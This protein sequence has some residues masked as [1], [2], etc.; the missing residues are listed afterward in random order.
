MLVEKDLPETFVKLRMNYF[1]C[2]LILKGREKL[3]ICKLGNL[4]ITV[5][6]YS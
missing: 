4:A 1:I 3:L 5:V 2:I 6:F